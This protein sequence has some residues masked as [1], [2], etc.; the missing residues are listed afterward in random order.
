[1]FL[2]DTIMG[3]AYQARTTGSW[4]TPPNSCDSIAAYPDFMS[5]LKNDEHIIFD[6]NYQRIRYV[7]EGE[8]R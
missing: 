8:M 1:M 3:E 6:P 5:S 2:Q 7:I 4:Q